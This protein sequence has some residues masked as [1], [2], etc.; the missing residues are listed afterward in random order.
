MYGNEVVLGYEFR[1]YDARIGRWWSIDPMADKYP[2]VG[3]YVFC[4]DNP[5]MLVDPSGSEV[6][7][8]GKAKKAFFREVKSGAKALGVSIRMDKSGKLSARY[9]GDGAISEHGQLFLNAIEDKTIKVNI[10]TIKNEVGTFTDYMFGGTFGGNVLIPQLTDG[11]WDFQ[12]SIA[13]QTVIPSDLKILDYYYELPG[14]SSLHEITEAYIGAMIAIKGRI[15]SSATGRGN[16]LFVPAHNSAIPQSGI[17]KKGLFDEEGRYVNNW[18][19]FKGKGYIEWQTTSG[20]LLKTSDIDT[21][22]LNK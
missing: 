16:P 22:D 9:K 7:I 3:P 13:K 21:D 10:E 18:D 19:D 20:E 14:Q 6:F 8:H 4:A 5:M 11:K 15:F 17:V 2:G 1:Q 12:F